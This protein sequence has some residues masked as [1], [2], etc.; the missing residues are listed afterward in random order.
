MTMVRK[1]DPTR[2]AAAADRPL[3]R[4]LLTREQVARVAL[5]FLDREGLEALS[6]RRLASELGVAAMTIYSYYASKEDLLEAVVD[7]AVADIAAPRHDGPWQ[8]QLTE[9][10]RHVRRGIERHPALAKLRASQPVLRPEALRFAEAALGILRGAG[11]DKRDAAMSF[12]L[13]FTY[14]F[15]YATFSPQATVQQA[16]A[17]AA[18]AITA[19]PADS[20]P[21]LTAAAAEAA[22]AMAG[23][24]AFEF[25]LA[26]IVKGIE[27]AASAGSVAD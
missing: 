20:Y 18:S 12:R 22:E 4:G 2:S 5:E 27:A 11:L 25:G 16:R 8:Q 26:L 10:L 15:G 7:V 21:Q 3:G 9:L 19:L 23:D 17:D 1:Q 14:V 6:M 24:E 13:L